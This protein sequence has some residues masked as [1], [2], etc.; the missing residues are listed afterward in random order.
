MVREKDNEL[1]FMTLKSFDFLSPMN[2][3]ICQFLVVDKAEVDWSVQLSFFCVYLHLL[4]YLKSLSGCMWL[5]Y[6]SALLRGANIVVDLMQVQH[7]PV[8][9]HCSDGWDRTSQIC[10][11]SELMMDKYYRTLEVKV[12]YKIRLKM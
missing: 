1:Y 6:I 8:L 4:S 2:V 11:L 10:S 3:L 7:R 9:V 12:E 5:T